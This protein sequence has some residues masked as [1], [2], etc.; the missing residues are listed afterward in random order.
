MWQRKHLKFRGQMFF[1][2][3]FGYGFLRF[4]L[5]IIRDDV[6]RG[7]YG[8]LLPEHQFVPGALFL[9]ALG[10]CFGISLG[11]RDKTM[12]TVSRVLSFVPA[13]VAYLAL[14][15]ATF[16][17]SISVQLSTSQWIALASALIVSYFYAQYWESARRSPKLAM[18]LGTLDAAT[19]KSSEETASEEEAAD[20]AQE[21]RS[22]AEERDDTVAEAPAPKRKKKKKG[23]QAKRASEQTPAPPTPTATPDPKPD[24]EEAPSEGAKP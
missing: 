22:E 19:P 14:K 1:L 13:I 2:F 15:P 21:A 3:V 17:S 20:D 8:P 6:E 11:I 18:S 4:L 7:E 10:F 5:E 23:S 16:G 24:P 9:M 12:R